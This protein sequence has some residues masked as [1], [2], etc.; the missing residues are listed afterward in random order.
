[1]TFKQA[2]KHPW[3]VNGCMDGSALAPLVSSL[4]FNTGHEASVPRSVT[5]DSFI[6]SQGLGEPHGRQERSRYSEAEPWFIVA[7]LRIN[8]T[9]AKNGTVA[10]MYGTTPDRSA[11]DEVATESGDISVN[12]HSTDETALNGRRHDRIGHASKDTSMGG[13]SF[14]HSR[15]GD[16]NDESH[17]DADHGPRS[18]FSSASDVEDGE[19]ATPP[20]DRTNLSAMSL[21]PVTPVASQG[22]NGTS[23]PALVP[24]ASVPVAVAEAAVEEGGLPIVTEESGSHNAQSPLVSTS[25]GKVP[26]SAKRR[27]LDDDDESVAQGTEAPRDAGVGVTAHNE[28]EN[29]DAFVDAETETSVQRHDSKNQ[30]SNVPVNRE[31]EDVEKVRVIEPPLK[32][33]RRSSRRSSVR[34]TTTTATRRRPSGAQD[35]KPMTPPPRRTRTSTA[36][37][38]RTSIGCASSNR[39]RGRTRT[40]T[41]ASV[42]STTADSP[43]G[44]DGPDPE[45]E[46]IQ[47]QGGSPFT[48]VLTRRRAKAARMA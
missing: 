15:S 11:Y 5:D 13:T 19:G 36:G 7:Q 3:L 12:A 43:R 42:A 41:P 39:T 6:D 35:S 29:E 17:P 28:A 23:V 37:Q 14:N 34:S 18:A 30:G 20:L 8:G 44:G 48:G 25:Q 10:A 24:L 9:P 4:P 16:N 38:G 21:D 46:S 22:P 2:L 26:G 31:E 47:A 45:P 40:G 1:M 33:A 32:A 27:R